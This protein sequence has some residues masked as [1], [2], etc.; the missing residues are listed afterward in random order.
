[1]PVWI[2][3]CFY[4]QSTPW[5]I[6]EKPAT[7][8]TSRGS[9]ETEETIDP[10]VTTMKP[11]SPKLEIHNSRSWGIKRVAVW[12]IEEIRR[13]KF[14]E[15]WVR[16]VERWLHIERSKSPEGDESEKGEER[17]RRQVNAT[18]RVSLM[19]LDMCIRRQK[20]RD[21]FRGLCRFIQQTPHQHSVGH[22]RLGEL[23]WKVSVEGPEF[24]SLMQLFQTTRRWAWLKVALSDFPKCRPYKFLT[25]DISTRDTIRKHQQ[26]MP[27]ICLQPFRFN[28][29]KSFL[30]NKIL[31]LK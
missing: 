4:L 29:Y 24:S 30:V 20:R 25:F 5:G 17:E 1:M 18:T 14:A 31:F 23:K 12:A 16:Q 22:K 11:A 13:E 19:Y 10:R 8:S 28:Y 15:S 21:L 7:S 9:T 6:P 27:N 2:V 26:C 3:S